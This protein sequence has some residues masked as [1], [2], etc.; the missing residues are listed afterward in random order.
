MY[1]KYLMEYCKEDAVRLFA[2]VYSD[3]MEGKN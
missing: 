2:V 1:K 3:T